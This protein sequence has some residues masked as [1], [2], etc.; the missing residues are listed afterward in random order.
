AAVAGG[1]K[2]PGLAG[3]VEEDRAR[4]E[5]RDPAPG[6]SGRI[7]EGRGFVVWTDFWKM[8]RGMLSGADIYC[9]HTVG[10][11]AFLQHDVDLVSVRGGPG[12]DVDH[13]ILGT[14]VRAKPAPTLGE[15][16]RPCSTASERPWA[17]APTPALRWRPAIP[18]RPGRASR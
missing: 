15:S 12:E 8:R 2:A 9:M 17:G 16:R 11:A 1:E 10:Q 3:P 5:K 18:S 7:R 6:G 13:G 4:F 14:W